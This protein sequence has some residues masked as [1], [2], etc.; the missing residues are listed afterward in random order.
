LGIFYKNRIKYQFQASWQGETWSFW[1]KMAC[2]FPSS[3]QV[4]PR[5]CSKG[6]SCF[7]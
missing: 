7:P 2:H 4:E 5:E 1:H 6:S 3:A